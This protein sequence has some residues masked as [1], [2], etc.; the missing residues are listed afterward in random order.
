[1]RDSSSEGSGV[2]DSQSIAFLCAKKYV[3]SKLKKFDT[4]YVLNLDIAKK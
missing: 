3:D 4:S 1:M 2:D